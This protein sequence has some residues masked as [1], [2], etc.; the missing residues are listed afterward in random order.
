VDLQRRSIG[1]V[2]V[3]TG[4]MGP[5]APLT[6]RRQVSACTLAI[7]SGESGALPDMR[8]LSRSSPSQKA[9]DK[10]RAE[11]GGSSSVPQGGFCPLC[12]NTTTQ[13]VEELDT[14]SPHGK[15]N[16]MQHENR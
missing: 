13:P 7:V 4:A 16:C 11:Q 5:K 10:G 2:T 15:I 1:P 12:V 14:P 6:A 8:V 9:V 3:K